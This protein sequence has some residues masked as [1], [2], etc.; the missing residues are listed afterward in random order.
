MD[1]ESTAGA[2]VSMHSNLHMGTQT[3]N[4]QV[5]EEEDRNIENIAMTEEI[6][7]IEEITAG[8][9][10]IVKKY[11]EKAE[12]FK[13]SCAIIQRL[14]N[15][16]DELMSELTMACDR[17]EQLTQE[18]EIQDREMLDLS[19]QLTQKEEEIFELE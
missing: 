19:Q 17:I 14:E 2:T 7:L 4:A 15:L 18:Q 12:K 9:R 8:A 16:N 11:F 3:Q 1:W 6:R 10:D 13:Q 5:P